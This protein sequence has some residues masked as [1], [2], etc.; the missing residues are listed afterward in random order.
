MNQ[1]YIDEQL[2]LVKKAKVKA[3]NH[4]IAMHRYR[5]DPAAW[6]VNRFGEDIRSI[7][8]SEYPEYKNHN[9]DGI[10]DPLWTAW[11]DVAHRNWVGVESASSTGKTYTLARI[12]FWFLDVY[13]NGLVVTSAPKRDQL[14]LHLWSE[15]SRAFDKFK[16]IRPYAELTTL[17]LRV[18]N[19]KTDESEGDENSWMATGF[20]AGVKANE[21]STTKAQGFHRENMLIITE[22]TPGMPAPTLKA[23]TTT[24][25]GG[26]NIILAVGNPDSITDPLHRFIVDFRSKVKHVIISGLDHPNVVLGREI[27]PGAITRGANQMKLEAYGEDNFFYQSRVRG[28]CPQQS[29]DSL[30]KLA[31]IDACTINSSKYEDI[32]DDWSNNALGIDVANSE[33]SDKACLAWGLRNTLISLHEFFC[34]NANH[35]AYNVLFDDLYLTEMGYQNYHTDKVGN[36]GIRPENIGV[37]A[38]GVGV[39]TINAF[40]DED[41]V[42]R[43]LQG[44]QDP[45]A[46]P[47]DDEN[48]DDPKPLWHFTTLRSQ[49]Y[50]QLSQDLQHRRI[51]IAITDNQILNQLKLELVTP[52]YASRDSG[53]VVESKESI[54]KRMG[55]KSPNM[56]DAM[57]YWNWVRVERKNVMGEMPFV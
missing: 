20:V 38:V 45:E 39:G 35:L 31:W 55:G 10:K 53:I 52:K 22:E 14:M 41:Y 5:S 7:K 17:K 24:S 21:D 23:F 33:A 46:I 2:V 18:D 16:R 11:N 3:L 30:I 26:N 4:Q 12:V 44:G 25:T 42:V 49:M 15:I 43:P 54:K 29:V 6:L 8:W 1:R 28:I 19:R 34:P 40:K 57:V 48:S 32:P 37:D 56:A 50:W 51:K 27:V 36:Y 47:V 9:W 13:E